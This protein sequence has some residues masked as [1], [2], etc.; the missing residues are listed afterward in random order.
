MIKEVKRYVLSLECQNDF[1]KIKH[2]QKFGSLSIRC[3][4]PPPQHHHRRHAASVSRFGYVV[5]I[6]YRDV[7]MLFLKRLPGF[8]AQR[9]SK[10]VSWGPF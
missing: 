6:M 5:I 2:A 7:S 3:P 8:I 10:T 1:A 4:R 9:S